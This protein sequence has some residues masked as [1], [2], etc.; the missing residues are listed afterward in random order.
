MKK[1]VVFGVGLIGSSFILA[2]KKTIN[3][4]QIIGIDRSKIRISQAYELG[5]LDTAIQISIEDAIYGA[6]L[7]LL[8]VPVT[9][10]TKILVS[11]LP[12]LQPKTIITD[13]G[14]TKINVIEVARTILGDKISQFIPGHPIAGREL[15]GPSAAL[16][17][18]YY[19]K[20]IV[21]TPL[22]ENRIQDIEYVIRVWQLCGGTVYSLTPC[23]HDSIFALVSHLPHFLAFALMDY[24]S[25][26]SNINILFQYAATGFQDFTRLSNSSPEMWR[27]ISLTNRIAL[28]NELD[29]YIV[30]L[31]R[32]RKLLVEYDGVNLQKIYTN[33]K[34]TRNNLENAIKNNKN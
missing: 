1:I 20:K 14:S 19:N 21:L 6:D 11:I 29:A 10:T 5:I 4:K 26:Q 17:N 12:Y 3:V 7:I 34:I 32:M 9:Q 24:I 18:L 25:A 33:A 2:L 31:I 13:T 22:P 23:E 15:H 30:Q 16:D 27:D 28:L 8:A